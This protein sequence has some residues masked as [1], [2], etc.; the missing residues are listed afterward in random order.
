M[1]IKNIDALGEEIFW[2]DEVVPEPLVQT[3]W[4]DVVNYGKWDK[5]FLAYGG[6]PPHP[7]MDKSGDPQLQETI[8]S[9]GSFSTDITG[10]KERQ[11]WY[12]NVSRSREAFKE[13]A[14]K[15]YKKIE[16]G[17]EPY[18][19]DP[20]VNEKAEETGFGLQEH[21]FNHHPMIHQTVN[22]IWSMYKKAFEEALGKEIQDY[23]NCYL[24]SFQHGDSS[25]THQDYMDYSAIVYLNP[26]MM[27]YWD[28]RKWGGETLYWN[29]DL[30]F[31]RAC[32]MPKGGAAS[33]FR[34]DI[35][36]KVTM[37]SW[38]AEF[39]RNAATFFFDKK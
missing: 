22:M 20:E 36:H 26:P 13:A 11:T 21:Q 29:D 12:M 34:G 19:E 17:N 7:S 2:I 23:N 4:Q 39:G 32:T 3:W 27:P 28:L 1:I 6:N 30:D 35:F 18:W 8:R 15:A 9:T 16:D 10:T 24:H 25:W 37:P 14:T 33:L 5:G 31:V 38:E